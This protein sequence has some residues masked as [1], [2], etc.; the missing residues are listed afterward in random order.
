MNSRDIEIAAAVALILFLLHRASKTSS[1]TQTVSLPSI[2]NSQTSASSQNLGIVLDNIGQ[3]AASLADTNDTGDAGDVDSLEDD[4][5]DSG[6][7]VGSGLN[8][9]DP[10]VTFD[11]FGVPDYQDDAVIK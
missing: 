6:L 10:W 8:Y 1:V 4:N 3:A 11:T 2:S 7:S 5:A 9:T